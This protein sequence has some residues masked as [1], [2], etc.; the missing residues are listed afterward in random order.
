MRATSFI[1]WMC[2]RTRARACMCVHL[3]NQ[4]K[5]C[6]TKGYR[7]LLATQFQMQFKRVRLVAWFPFHSV[8]YGLVQHNAP[9]SQFDAHFIAIKSDLNVRFCKR[10][11][12]RNHFIMRTP[13]YLSFAEINI[14]INQR[15]TQGATWGCVRELDSITEQIERIKLLRFGILRKLN[16][17]KIFQ[18]IS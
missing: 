18:A 12:H 5:V 4:H 16:E 11:F 3:A 8:C 7:R 14:G 15:Y 17:T 2:A 6:K 10:I 9:D 1:N 13:I